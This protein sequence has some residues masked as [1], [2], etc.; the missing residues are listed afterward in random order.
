MTQ[1]TEP[2]A[3]A[4]AAATPSSAGDVR[5]L[6]RY[7]A[8]RDSGVPWLGA[9]PAHWVIA[10]IYARYS[11]QLGKM[12]SPETVK[13]INP[14]PYLRNANVQWDNIDLTDVLEMDFS[15]EERRKYELA[16]GDLLV[17]EGGEVGRCAIWH[18]ELEPCFIQN[19]IHRV[20]PLGSGD[21]TRFLFYGMYT[22]ASYGVFQA[23]GNRSTIVHLTAEKLKMRRIAFPPL[24]EQRAIAA[25]LD[26]ETAR[27]DALVAAKRRLIELLREKRAALI[28]R[29]VTRGLDASVPLR[30][31]GVPWLGAVPAHWEVI[32]LRRLAAPD[33]SIT[34]GIVQAGPDIEGGIPYIRTSDMA[35]D[36]LPENGYLRTSPD[37]DRQYQ[38]SKVLA[39]DLVVAIRATVGKTLRVPPY[40]DGANLTQG[41]ARISPGPRVLGNFLLNVM[42]SPVI[43][44]RFEAL[45][46]GATFKEITLDM[47]RR[48]SVPVPPLD[49][50]WAIAAY[51][52]AETAK[53]D[54]LAGRI[55]QQIARLRE[56]RTALIAAAVTGAIDVRGQAAGDGTDGER[57]I[58]G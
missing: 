53:L 20:R 5:A 31:S 9:I 52:D 37:I 13:G 23:E 41:T 45:S 40:L 36:H 43:Q 22:A 35:G 27:I 7:P 42:Q 54:T 51:L 3:P 46:K 18:G 48:L 19:A 33:T 21:D 4:V 39:N 11:V 38:R 29:A 25:F 57:G 28:S 16:P 8:Y 12:L 47:L 50:Q 58:A 55:E 56:Y 10:P 17:C 14:A 26:R 24:A 30:E 1:T 6:P 2:T 32:Q 44:Q 49:E 15:P 34:Y